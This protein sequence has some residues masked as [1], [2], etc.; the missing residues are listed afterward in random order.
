MNDPRVDFVKQVLD[1]YAHWFEEPGR[2]D[3]AQM[4]SKNYPYSTL[5]SPIQVNRLTLKNRIV[6]GPMGNISMAEE[7]GRPSN[8]MIQYFADRARGGAGLLTSG[9]VPISQAVDPTVTERGNKSY[10]PR[11]DSSR[12]VFSGWRD[13]AESVHAYGCRFFIQLTAGLG[14]VGSPESLLTKFRMP[15][16]ASWNPNFYIPGIPCRPLTDGECRTIIKAAGQGAADAKA[17]T[18]DGV[19]LHGH[20]GYLLEQMTNPAFNR[21]KLGR[22]AN[23]Q[24]FGLDMVK[25]VRKRVGLNFPI[26]YRIDLSLALNE[27]YGNR[28]DTV[29]SLRKFKKER[30]VAETLEY[31]V[32]LVKAGVDLFDV[33]LGCYDNW[34]LPHPPNSMPSGCFLPVSRLVKEWFAREKVLSNAGLPV[35]I[36]AVGKLG[37]PDL[38]E[39]ALRNGE[40]DMIMLARPLLAD[41]EWPNKAYAGNVMDIC[42]CIGDQEGCINEF[43]EGGHLQCSVNPR[44]GFEDVYVRELAPTSSPKKVAIIGAGPA[45]ILCAITAAHRRHRVALFEKTDRVGGM[46]VPGSV[47]KIK[48]EVKNYLVY[49]EHQLKACQEKYDLTVELNSEVTPESLKGKGF[50][51]V[52]V[53]VGGSAV[54]PRLP[55]VEQQNVIQAIDLFRKPELAA[56][57]RNVVVVGAG[58]VGCEA[59][60]FLSAELGKKVTVVE[61]LPTI[62]PGLCTANRGHLIHELENLGVLLWNCTKLL[63]IEGNNVKLARNVS[64]TVPDPYVTWTPLLPENISNPFAKPI[65]E[66]IEEQTIPAELVVLAMGLR[67]GR[68]FYEACVTTQAAP[69]VIQ[70]GDTFQIG[71]VFEAVKS[72][73]L[74]GRNL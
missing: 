56:K 61:M 11:I 60:Q 51:T 3:L 32:N 44:T 19:Y 47:A 8:K 14:R 22:F 74:V 58:A 25:V 43:V 26:M 31:M 27:T 54:T 33:D 7:M 41:A 28:M 48:Y 39:Q 45:G 49:L 21:R 68:A 30:T 40:C 18:I 1:Q 16:S 20:E 35:P 9:L 65:K 34:W 29:A 2:M 67:S 52:V 73:S 70:L 12:T 53:S 50:D 62:M 36:V 42:P 38:A 71:R 5:F 10:F 15:V 17:A 72:G 66:E 37:Y 13:L 57:A 23:W 4:T 64:A 69:E 46:L 24:N 55:G 59:A 6:M 63:S